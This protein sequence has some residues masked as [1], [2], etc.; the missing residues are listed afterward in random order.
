MPSYKEIRKDAETFS[1]IVPIKPT[2]VT[3]DKD[4]HTIYPM[5]HS[6]TKGVGKAQIALDSALEMGQTLRVPRGV[7]TKILYWDG[8]TGVVGAFNKEGIQVGYGQAIWKTDPMKREKMLRL[9]TYDTA[10]IVSSHFSGQGLG[11]AMMQHLEDFIG[12]NNEGIG[13]SFF[14]DVEAETPKTQAAAKRMLEKIGAKPHENGVD[15]LRLAVKKQFL[16]G[17]GESGITILPEK[18]PLYIKH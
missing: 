6:G 13:A 3:I 15:W 2:Q 1:R 14:Y 18:V 5:L 11:F 10:Y 12:L 8:A 16:R 17:K 4:Y 9:M 7:K